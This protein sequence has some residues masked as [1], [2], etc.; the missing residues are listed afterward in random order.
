MKAYL[1]A[2]ILQDPFNGSILAAG[3][4]LCLEDDAKRPIAHD[5]AL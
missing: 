1:E 2:F 5:L 4:H 3:H